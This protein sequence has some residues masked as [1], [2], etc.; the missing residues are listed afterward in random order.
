MWSQNTFRLLI[1][2]CAGILLGAVFFHMTP[3]VSLIL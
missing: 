1:S 2:F 3:V